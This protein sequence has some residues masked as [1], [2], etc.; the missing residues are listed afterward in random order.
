[1][2]NLIIILFLTIGSLVSAQHKQFSHIFTSTSVV[3][4]NVIVDTTPQK[5][6]IYFNYNNGALIKIHNSDVEVVFKVL[7]LKKHNTHTDILIENMMTGTKLAV[8]IIDNRMYMTDGE[9]IILFSN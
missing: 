1:M 6:I 3:E 4:N 5:T 9:T 8:R 7:E 2:K